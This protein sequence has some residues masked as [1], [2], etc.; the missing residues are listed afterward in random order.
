VPKKDPDNVSQAAQ[1]EKPSNFIYE[2]FTPVPW[3]KLINTISEQKEIDY[4]PNSENVSR[5]SEE[6]RIRIR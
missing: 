4:P 2:L 3:E 1:N 5:R 6:V